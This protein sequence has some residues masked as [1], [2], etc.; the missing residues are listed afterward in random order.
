[1]D[2]K[3]RK[4]SFGAETNGHKWENWATE[5][6]LESLLRWPQLD[7]GLIHPGALRF[8]REAGIDFDR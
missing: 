4:F 8:Y 7:P 5:D 6:D 1:M 2:V 3:G